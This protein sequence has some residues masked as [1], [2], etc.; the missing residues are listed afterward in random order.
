M[1]SSETIIGVIR[2]R[3]TRLHVCVHTYLHHTRIIHTHTRNANNARMCEISSRL[4]VDSFRFS[5][6]V[7]CIR[8]SRAAAARKVWVSNW[9]IY[10]IYYSLKPLNA[11]RR[12]QTDS[13]NRSSGALD[14]NLY[15]AVTTVGRYNDTRSISFRAPS[16]CLPANPPT[17]RIELRR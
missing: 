4:T 12:R 13:D 6:P 2:T 10:F 11:R 16:R 17:S 15:T 9:I 1:R 8:G 14:V 3:I 7:R 5:V